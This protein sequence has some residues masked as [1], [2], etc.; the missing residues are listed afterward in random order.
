MLEGLLLARFART[1]EGAR[2][3][4]LSHMTG[5]PYMTAEST[6]AV[7]PALDTQFLL[8]P[9]MRSI[10]FALEYSKADILLRDWGIRSTIIVFGGA[11]CASPESVHILGLSADDLRVAKQLKWYNDARTFGRIASER[12]GAFAPKHRWRDNVIATGG[13]PGLM[14]AAN[15]GA[16]D[17]GAPTIGFNIKLPAEQKSNPLHHPGIEFS[18]P[19]LR[20][21]EDASGDARECAGDIPGWIRYNGRTV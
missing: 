20:D 9:E 13:G 11:R 12:G 4:F 8:R 15:R 17:V 10:R 21:A 6:S 2:R 3:Q 16:R 1:S 18:I 19:L 7:L 5:T 14:E